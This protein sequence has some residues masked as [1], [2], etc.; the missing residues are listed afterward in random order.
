M[1]L[2]PGE[3]R[4]YWKHHSPGKWFRQA[5][6]TD[7]IHNEKA[8]LLLDTCAEVSVV[9]TAF[10]R[11]VGCY[12]E[13]S[14]IQDCMGIG[15]NVYRTEG[16]TRI[17][18]TLAGSLVYFFDIWVGDLTG[19]QAI[20]GMDFMVPAGIRVDLAHGSISL[21][22]E[23]QIQLSGRRQLYSD[24]AKIVNV[25]QYLRIQAGELVELPLRLRSSIYDKL[26]VARGERW[27]PTIS[28][29]PGRTRYISITNIG[30]EVLILHQGQR[31]GIWLAGDHVPRIQGFISIG[32]RRYMEW[33]NLALEATTD[34]RSEEM[35]VKI[36]LVPAV[37]RSGYETPRAILQRPKATLIQ[38]RKVGASQDQDIPDCL[39]SDNSPS[40]KPPSDKSPTEIRPLDLASVASE[41]SDLSFIADEDSISHDATVNEALEDL[42]QV[43]SD[44]WATNPS[45]EETTGVVEMRE[46]EG[47]DG[48][49]VACAL[50]L[51]FTRDSDQDYD[52]CVYYHE[53][54][55]LYAEDIDGEMVV[56]PEVPVTTE[57]VKIED[58]QLCRS[59]NQT[60]EEIDRLR[61]RIWKFRHLLIGKG[62]ALPPAAR[63][64]VCDID[65]GG[66]RPVALKCRKLW[67]QFREKLADLIKGL[68]SAKM[69]NY[70]IS[71]WASPIVVI[72]KKNGVDIMLCI[73]YRLVSSLTQLMVC[74][75]P[76]I[77]DLVED[78]EST[79]CRFIEDCAIYASVLYEL[80]ETDFAAMMKDTTQAQIQ[81]VLEVER[82]DQGSQED[83]VIDHRKTLD[84]EAQDFTEVDPRWIHAY[85]SFSVLKAKIATT[86]ILRHFDPDR[87]ATV[88]VYASDWAIS[89]SLMQEYDKI[90][91]PVVFA[92]RTLKSNELNYGIAV[93]PD[94]HWQF[95]LETSEE[96]GSS[97]TRLDRNRSG[98]VEA[99]TH[100]CLCLSTGSEK[101]TRVWG[102]PIPQFVVISSLASG[103]A[104]MLTPDKIMSSAGEG[105]QG[106]SGMEPSAATVGVYMATTGS[107]PDQSHAA[108]QPA[109][110]VPVA[111]Y[112]PGPDAR[113]PPRAPT[114]TPTTTRGGGPDGLDEETKSD[115]PMVDQGPRFSETGWDG[116]QDLREADQQI[117]ELRAALA[118]RDEQERLRPKDYRVARAA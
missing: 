57:D 3:S 25:G 70:S 96:T 5:K 27:V 4:G 100:R 113:L 30:D 107:G 21:P 79:L 82:V 22:D 104:P 8:I 99:L 67:V 36:P 64:V 45:L 84:L 112:P 37:E 85:R 111:E 7:K 42:D 116:G 108:E 68:L 77:N 56:L 91:Y 29:G 35:E 66:A 97:P 43:T 18:V 46:E 101:V 33:Q 103:D 47:R 52:E 6:I 62:N 19:Q 92:S 86:P 9:D 58:I 59:D 78:L 106:S 89:G 1:D 69:I 105:S 60:P 90:Y 115:A 109:F 102:G 53:G 16:R 88:V 76:L 61:Q 117:S 39:P 114:P 34:T 81:R 20:L 10:A 23:V 118:T 95:G 83:Q 93:A 24:K 17:K 73:D 38:Y 14:Q 12:I 28:D 2:L 44:V 55:D 63:G 75:M 72:I 15:D 110:Y 13:S 74:P 40:D 32:S 26:W 11:K 41:E 94:P 50:D 49:G 51:D 87:N 65:V 80:R 98:V 48:I 54:S 71:P 31:I